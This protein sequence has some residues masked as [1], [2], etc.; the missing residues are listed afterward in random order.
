[1]ADIVLDV[2]VRER[3]G[4]GNARATRRNRLV[5]GVLYGG[6]EDPVAIELKQNEVIRAINSGKLLAKMIRL[7]HKGKKQFAITQDVQFH[8]VS[9]MP[10]H[11]DFYRVKEDTEITIEVGTTF[12]GEDDSPGLRR[13]GTLNVVRYM[14]EVVCPAGKIPETI[15][16]DLSGLEIGD[17]VHLSDL[18]FPEGVHSS[19]VDRD[20]TVLTVVGSRAALVNEEEDL[21]EGEAEE[22]AEM[23]GEG[24]KD[25]SKGEA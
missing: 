18:K 9:D 13:G 5:P 15:E 4:K 21:E 14:I 1:M 8:P 22:G 7:S 2:K 20:A 12:T 10:E 19:I 23:E 17:S 11:V 3:T 6:A 16:V 24:G 25:E